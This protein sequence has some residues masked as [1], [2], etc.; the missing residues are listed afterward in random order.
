MNLNDFIDQFV[1]DLD[2]DALEPWCSIFGVIYEPPVADDDWPDWEDDLRG[3]IMDKMK[4]TTQ[5]C[6]INPWRAFKSL[7]APPSASKD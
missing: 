4:H 2:F 7:L 1:E 3:T 6:N 5:I